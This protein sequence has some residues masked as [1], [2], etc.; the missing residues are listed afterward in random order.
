MKKI[1]AFLLA[2]IICL[3]FAAC[4]GEKTTDETTTTPTEEVQLGPVEITAEN[5]DTYFEFVEESIFTKNAS[6]EVN[7]LRFRH[8]YKLKDKYNIDSTKSSINMTYS[9]TQ[10]TKAIKIDFANQKFTLGEQKGETKTYEN[11][12]VAKISKMTYKNYAIFFLQ[13]DHAVKGDSEIMY[14]SDFKVNSV[15]G[16]L[17]LIE[18][19][20]VETHTHAN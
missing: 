9:Y 2:T 14:F 19:K 1:I 8:Y 18:A 16:T 5:F 11:V 7:A 15:T 10:S 3:S 4:N 6:G 17:Y 20:N 13:P 12:P